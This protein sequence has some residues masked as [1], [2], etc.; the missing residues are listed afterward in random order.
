MYLLH[1]HTHMHCAAVCAYHVHMYTPKCIWLYVCVMYGYVCANQAVSIHTD[2]YTYNTYIP[3]IQYI[4]QQAQ[5]TTTARISLGLVAIMASWHAQPW[6]GPPG[7][8]I[9]CHLC[10]Q[11]AVTAPATTAA[12]SSAAGATAL[13][14]SRRQS[15]P[16]AK[17]T[18]NNRAR[19]GRP[20]P[21]G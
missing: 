14:P 8:L 6:P 5:R 11:Q 1:V 20:G 17:F 16:R 18:A 15:L 12:A 13:S 2:T 21:C 9:R 7:L 4:E 3:Y 10:R 19:I